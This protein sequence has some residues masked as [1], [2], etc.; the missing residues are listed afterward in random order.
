AAYVGLLLRQ[1]P[2]DRAPIDAEVVAHIE[3]I[4]ARGPDA[5]W[6]SGVER[7]DIDRS[8]AGIDKSRI[9]PSSAV[10]ARHELA[11][12]HREQGLSWRRGDD[13][14]GNLGIVGEVARR[15]IEMLASVVADEEPTLAE[16]V[17]TIRDGTE[18]NRARRRCSARCLRAVP[19]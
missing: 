8:A 15:L 7:T 1:S 19:L 6:R 9:P 4:R 13:E 2:A 3:P 5:A 18:G 16:E 12:D 10:R 14:Q 17:H 11:V